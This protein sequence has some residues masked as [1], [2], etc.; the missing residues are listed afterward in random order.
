MAC[1]ERSAGPR[2]RVAAVAAGPALAAVTVLVAGILAAGIAVA[3][4]PPVDPE[5][6]RDQ[7]RDVMSGSAYDYSPSILERIQEWISDLF[8][9]VLPDGGPAPAGTFGGGAGSL[10]GF[11]VVALALAALVAVVVA[12]VRNRVARPPAEEALSGSEVEHRRRA[13]DWASE[14]ER[15]EAAG[16]WK[17]A[18]RARYR[19]LVRTLVD[20]RQLPDIA[21]RTTGE[22][23]ADLARTTPAASEDFDTASL[24]FE[25]PW[26]ADVTTGPEENAR[27]RA[28]ADRVL[29]A[30]PVERIDPSAV[31]ASV[32]GRVEVDR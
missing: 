21:G 22:L 23:R 11:L 7:V 26:Y 24:L 1:A 30:G 28:A 32:G 6:A 15:H 17:E 27:F 16:E 3:Q 20:R 31:F 14:A 2:A 29:A 9:R 5:V 8:D 4:E 18:V 13:D 25:L 19:A 10:V 12:V